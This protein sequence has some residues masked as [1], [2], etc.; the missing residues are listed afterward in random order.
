[1]REQK[2]VPSNLLPILFRRT[3]G[4]TRNDVTRL[5]VYLCEQ[6]KE[7]LM[8]KLALGIVAA[9]TLLAAAAPAMAQVGIYAGPGGVGVGVGVPGPYYGYPNGYYDYYGGP[10]VVVTPGWHRRWHRHWH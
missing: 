6:R 7:D 2:F 9:A 5:C 10:G 4:T 1:V 8:R 3:L